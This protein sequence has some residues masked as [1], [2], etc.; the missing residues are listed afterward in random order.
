MRDYSVTSRAVLIY[1]LVLCMHT[2]RDDRVSTRSGAI[3]AACSRRTYAQKQP[4]PA[5]RCRQRF[6]GCCCGTAGASG[7]YSDTHAANALVCSL[8]SM[9]LKGRS[10]SQTKA[11]GNGSGC[12][13]AACLSL[14]QCCSSSIS[15]VPYIRPWIE[16]DL[17]P[18]TSTVEPGM[19]DPHAQQNAT[20]L[21]L[22]SAHHRRIQR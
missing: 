12:G 6:K 20:T 16:R 3:P 22:T 2:D 9:S 21:P 4:N 8:L 18:G 15:Q 13:S 19:W 10:C 11:H 17:A 5:G 7:M 14:H 1:A